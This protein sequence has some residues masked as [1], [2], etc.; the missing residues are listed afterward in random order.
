MLVHA[1]AQREEYWKAD[2]G[3]IYY[4]TLNIY[5][6]YMVKNNVKLGGGGACI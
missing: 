5:C 4:P 3:S 2:H 6:I 1:H